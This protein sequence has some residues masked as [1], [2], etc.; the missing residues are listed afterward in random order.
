MTNQQH[1]RFSPSFALTLAADARFSQTDY[2]DDQIWEVS[3]GEASAPALALQTRYG[4][5]VGL[6]SLVPMWIHDGRSIY[7]VQT[8]NQAPS[9]TDFAPGFAQVQS[10]IIPDLELLTE[11]WAMESHA[12]GARFTLHNVG[13]QAITLRLDLFGHIASE[14]INR[15]LAILTLQDQTH[16]LALG[17]IGNLEPIV[18]LENAR[19]LLSPGI[20]ASPKIG[21]DLT[22][23]AGEKLSLRWVHAG[24]SKMGDSLERA[25]FWL[26]QDWDNAFRQIQ[27]AA[28][29]IPQVITGDAAQDTAIAYAYH[30]LMQSFL[31]PT[32]KLPFASFV[33]TRQAN[34]GWSKRGDGTDY[35]RAW[36]GQH[37]HVAY[38]VALA[39]APIAPTFAQGLLKNYLVTQAEDGFIDFKPGLAGQTEGMLYPPILA[40]MAWQIFNITQDTDFLKEVFS[41]L[42]KFFSRWFDSDV[43]TNQNGLPEWQ[44]ERQ[45]GYVSWPT[46]SV[47]QAWSQG[48]TIHSVESPDLAAYLVSEARALA[49]IA[50]QINDENSQKF[51]QQAE[52]LTLLLSELWFVSGKH[53]AYRDRDTNLTSIGILILR[54]ARGDEEQLPVI[55]IS[56]ASRLVIRL[57]GGTSRPPRASLYLEGLDSEGKSVSETIAGETF[58]WS[59]GSGV[60]TSSKIY[61]QIDRVRFTGLSRVYRVQVHTIDLTRLD[62]NSLLPL[63]TLPPQDEKQQALTNLLTDEK[64]FWR[65]SGLS[66]VSAQDTNYDSTSANGGG[67][68]WPYFVTLIGEA[69]ITNN[70]QDLAAELLKRLLKTQAEVLQ[71]QDGFSEFYDSDKA[72][73][74]GESDYLGG[75]V[76][77][78]LLMRVLGV[79]ITP[80]GRVWIGGKLSWGS[81]VTVTQYQ[82][83]VHRSDDGT[84]IHFPDGQVI[85][86]PPDAIPRWVESPSPLVMSP[87]IKLPMPPDLLSQKGNN[88]VIIAIQHDT[89][90]S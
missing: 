61:A 39:V 23:R 47:G 29:A 80:T 17:K 28:Y 26:A 52:N 55:K 7:E 20:K 59:Y 8:Y 83:S 35:D 37:P 75:I 70:R 21:V 19:T 79:Q 45:T 42:N 50:Q 36:N 88:R 69:L 53:F 72:L 14:K 43:D 31:C 15:S 12:V 18:M 78:H 87:T 10:K 73:G 60:V 27:Q 41:A 51:T 64:H 68:V 77:L 2:T 54:D 32:D 74:L 33:A 66:M 63:L 4:G 6:A 38:L 62:L 30:Q 85:T 84:T 71:E 89:D 86:L 81:P 9:I 3:P 67:G 24:L 11:F 58:I 56:P 5:R 57:T 90:P 16:A 34:R 22:I 44:N 49:L 82:V 13:R 1:W 48:V 65:A 76:P 46:F 40:R 25:Q